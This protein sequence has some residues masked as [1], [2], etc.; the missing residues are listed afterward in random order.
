MSPI[1]IAHFQ[2][3]VSPA[4]GGLRSR[5]YRKVSG[6]VANFQSSCR[7]Q[8]IPV[9]AFALDSCEFWRKGLQHFSDKWS[10]LMLKGNG[11]HG[12]HSI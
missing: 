2:V 11:D 12:D 10:L 5:K 7:C 4:A 3:K 1:P 8:R 9:S 6:D